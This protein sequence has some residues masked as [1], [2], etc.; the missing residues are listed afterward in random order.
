[1]SEREKKLLA[2][3]EAL[4]AHFGT[5]T[6]WRADSPFEVSIGAI[7]TQNTAWTNVE[8]AIKNLKDQQCLNPKLM[9]ELSEAELAELIKP[10]GFFRVKTKRIKNFLTFLKQES[11][12]AKVDFSDTNLFYLNEY[13]HEELREKLLKISG[14]GNETA[15]TVL[16]YALNQP[17]FVIDAY[18]A[19]VFSRHALVESEINYLDLQ[20]FFTDVLPLDTKLYSDYHALIVQVA[21]DYCLKT[22]PRCETCPLKSFLEHEPFI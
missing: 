15:D 21:K 9:F 14:I 1:M 22:K 17:A 4:N 18:T 6:W 19:R 10:A 16:L 3:Y 13:L 2:Y 20:T 12:L 8:K 11:L 7:L 5:K